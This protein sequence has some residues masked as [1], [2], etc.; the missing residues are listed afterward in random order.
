MSGKDVYTLVPYYEDNSKFISF[1]EVNFNKKFEPLNINEIKDIDSITEALQDRFYYTGNI[2]LG[3]SS[4]VEESSNVSDSNY[5]FRSYH[6]FTSNYAAYCSKVQNAN[7]VFGVR[8]GGE[9][10]HVIGFYN[11]GRSSRCLSAWMC[12]ASNDVYY[13]M[14]VVG[15]QDIMFSFG[16]VGKRHIIGN[17]QL[18]PDKYRKIK[19]KLIDDI[20][21]VLKRDKKIPFVWDLVGL[22][23]ISIPHDVIKEASKIQGEK[24]DK[25]EIERAFSSTV[26]IILKRKLENID[27]YVEYL[28][29][30]SEVSYRTKCVI[31][32]KPLPM[33]KDVPKEV[34]EKRI[35]D[36]NIV[37]KF[38]DRF[39]LGDENFIDSAG[40]SGLSDAMKE[41]C[42]VPHG[43]QFEN[44]INNIDCTITIGSQNCLKVVAPILSQYLAYSYWGRYC[45][46]LFGCNSVLNSEFCIR[47]YFSLD[48]KRGF[49]VDN[50]LHCADIYFSH[51][52]EGVQDSM[53]C[54]N[55]KS[56]SHALG[57]VELELSKYT[58]IKNK[59][60][61]EI[62]ES[63][64]KNKDYKWNIFNILS[65]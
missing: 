27:N 33:P 7:Y 24:K 6:I 64:E 34:I 42:I 56:K 29:Q 25:K 4:F 58:N 22:K 17:L 54:F 46:Y 45:A 55:T 21:V 3:N 20:R 63:L 10:Q 19:E 57:N 43:Q 61:Q 41:K 40:F 38:W 44:N 8:F 30:Y 59:L 32:G 49:E 37:I 14:G 52:C 62:S 36:W 28:S 51:N 15:S 50:C 5:V 9:F 48:L 39:P 18:V 47:S 60:L 53:F 65:S 26:N 2:I 1:D 13:S 31:T 23:P 16:M 35:C 11:G 12:T